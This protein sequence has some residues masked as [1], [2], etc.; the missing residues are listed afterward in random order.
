[1][2]L[3]IQVLSWDRHRMTLNIQILSWDRLNHVFY[4]FTCCAC[5]RTRPEFSAS[6]CACPRTRPESSASFYYNY[7]FGIFKLLFMLSMNNT[8]KR[9]PKGEIKNE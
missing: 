9:Q 5:P 8:H 6:F 2:T 1:M 4:E 3:K 7:S